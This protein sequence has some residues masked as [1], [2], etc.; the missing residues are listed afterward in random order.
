MAP[1]SYRPQKSPYSLKCQ[2][3][4]KLVYFCIKA[5]YQ[6]INYS[7]RHYCVIKEAKEM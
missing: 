6:I 1:K 3:K 5:Y 7:I 4:F 2:K